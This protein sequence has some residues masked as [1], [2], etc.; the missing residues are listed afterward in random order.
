MG[1]APEA[2]VLVQDVAR[3]AGARAA[4]T[5]RRVAYVTQTTLSVDETSEIIGVLRERF[6]AIRGPKKEDICYA[7][8][9][10]QWAVKDMLERDRPPARD[11]L[12]QL[13]QLEPAG[14]RRPRRRGARRT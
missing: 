8:S 2:T 6:P 13:V 5:E 11:R 10:R 7:T 4:R 12:A 3:G 9:N 14:R 1:E